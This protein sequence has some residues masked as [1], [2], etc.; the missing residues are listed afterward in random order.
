MPDPRRFHRTAIFLAAATALSEPCLSEEVPVDREDKTRYHILRPTPRELLRDLSTD[1]PDT[2]ESPY[3]VDAG[4]FQLE[5]S[6]IDFTHDRR[7]SA[8]ETRNALAVSPL[9]LK[10]GL[11]HDLDLQLGLDPWVHEEVE[12]RRTGESATVSGFG[13]TF[14]RAKWNLWGND[15][16]MT[17]FALMPYIKLPTAHRDI[18]NGE[19]EGGLIAPL[20][21]SLP[22]EFSL[23]LMAE[24]DAV[25]NA[26]D[27]R[28]VAD[29]L[30]TLALG[31]D[32]VDELG[33]Y[34]EYAGL[35]DLSGEEAYRAYFDAGLTFAISS[36]VQI[37]CGI[38][39]GLTQAA[40][41]IGAF[42]GLSIRV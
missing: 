28:Y 20:A 42:V 1:R 14:L 15:S 12:D 16:G 32:L 41:D 39:V 26:D 30:H 8:R 11:L 17:A 29:F 34:I 13:D 7:N 25:R 23:G 37:D 40:D 18:G 6:L 36:E 35:S 19:V 9:L 31:H 27:D 21:V 5:M 10:A 38:R 4:R 24:I 2:T 22:A 3:S 33:A